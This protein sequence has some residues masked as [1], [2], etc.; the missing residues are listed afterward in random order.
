MSEKAN[1]PP[2]ENPYETPTAKPPAVG[3]VSGSREDLWKVARYQRGIIFCIL[4]QLN[5]FRVSSQAFSQGESAL[6]QEHRRS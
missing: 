5:L 2:E 1:H 6:R 4:I 3:V